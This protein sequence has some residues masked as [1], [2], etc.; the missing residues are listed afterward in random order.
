[1]ADSDLTRTPDAR[2]PA[3]GGSLANHRFSRLQQVN[4]SNVSSLVPVWLHSTGIEGAL[5]TTP[6][7]VDNTLYATTARG[8]VLAL[9]AATGERLWSRDPDPGTVTL[10]CGPSNKGVSVYSR[11]VYVSSLDARLVALDARSGE[12]RWEAALADPAL[13][14]SATMAPLA[15]DGRVFVGVSGQRYGIRGFLAAFDAESGEELWRWHSIPADS[16]GW[17]GQWRA[18]DPFGTPLDR[19]I[20][21]ERADSFVTRWTWG[22]GGGGIATTPAYDPEND[23][24]YVNV[25]GP[26]P[27]VDGGVR[28]GDNLYTGSIVALDARTGDLVWYAQYL[29]H[30]VWGLAGGSP[31]FLFE[32]GGE[33]YVAFAGRTGW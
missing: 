9:N 6:V 26:A 4:R 10:C 16:P 24:L 5:E 19:D 20:R 32:R 30:D 18:T 33:R 12:P 17:W 2:W 1:V 21:G 25:E 14:Y 22:V 13:G 15:A 27:V 29:P 31:P 11:M 28:P 7:V 3:N 23:R 8:R